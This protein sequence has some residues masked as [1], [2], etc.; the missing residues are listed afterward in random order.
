MSVDMMIR[1]IHRSQFIIRLSYVCC[2]GEQKRNLCAYYLRIDHFF[3][4]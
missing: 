4:R 1:E 2:I 3:S